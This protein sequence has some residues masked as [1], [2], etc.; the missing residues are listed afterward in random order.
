MRVEK[1]PSGVVKEYVL[2]SSNFRLYFNDS[3]VFWPVSGFNS[4]CAGVR[5]LPCP[6]DTAASLHSAVL[7]VSSPESRVTLDGCLSGHDP[8]NFEPSTR[9]SKLL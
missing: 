9:S 5:G 1:L 3:K 7:V 6:V 8:V 2:N 4:F